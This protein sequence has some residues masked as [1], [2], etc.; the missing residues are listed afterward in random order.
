MAYTA[1]QASHDVTRIKQTLNYL[2]KNTSY[3]TYDQAGRVVSVKSSNGNNI[4]YEYLAGKILRRY[5]ESLRKRAYA[6]TMYLNKNGMVEKLTS[7]NPSLFT[8]KRKFDAAQNI[9]L[10][11]QYSVADTVISSIAYVYSGGN[12]VSGMGEVPGGAIQAD[13]AI[14]TTLASLIQLEMKI[15]V[16]HL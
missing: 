10:E 3:Y 2:N 7:S 16:A 11:E 5:T 1:T 15:W 9:I 13:L 6:D 4:S 14:P 12:V 8:I